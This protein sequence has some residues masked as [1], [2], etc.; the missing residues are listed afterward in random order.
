VTARREAFIPTRADWLHAAVVSGALFVLYALT[1]PR[2]VAGEDDGLF[3]LSSYYLGVEHAPG[4]PLFTLVGKLFTLL[5]FGSVAYRVH[6]ASAF[7]GALSGGACWLCA[8]ALL[9][10][11]VAA[12]LAAGA[13]A[14]SQVFWSQSVI[15]EVYTLNTFFFLVLAYLGLQGGRRALAW[16]AFLFGL[17]LSN[18]WPLMLLAG[19]ALAVLVW[20]RLAEQVKRVPLLVGFFLVGLTPYAWMVFL[21]WG[22]SPVNF[23]GPLQ[24]WTEIWYFVSRAGYAEIDVRPSA[25]W[26]DRLKFMAFV[27]QQ[28][29]V[30]FVFI[31]TALA[32][33]GCVVQWRV[34][35]KRIAAF[36]LLAFLGPT[37]GL[38][39]LLNFDYDAFQKHIFHVYP[40]PAYAVVALWTGLGFAWL[41]ERFVL[42]PVTAYGA[43]AVLGLTFLAAG[44]RT[45]LLAD[46]DWS[47]RYAQAVLRALPPDAVVFVQG[48]ADLGPMAYLHMV[49]NWRPDITLY[50]AKGLILGNRLFHPLRVDHKTAQAEVDNL[51]H[52]ETRPVVFTLD[53]YLGYARR[54]RWLYIEVDKSS[55]DGRRLA[56]DIPE[57][58]VR[59]FEDSLVSLNEPNNWARFFQGELRR[60]YATL[61]ARSLTPGVAAS[62]RTSRHMDLLAKDLYGAL[63]LA[64]GLMAHPA[65]YSA[66][67]VAALLERARD[68]MPSDAPKLHL[69]RF[70]HLRGLLR[71]D[72][73]DREGGLRDLETALAVWPVADNPAREPLADFQ[74]QAAKH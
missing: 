26:L 54:D 69:S 12:H 45:N 72:L 31:G 37:A 8:R 11:R 66:G 57:D 41:A 42:R 16:I 2:T 61:L 14:L 17:S 60:R 35:G 22:P 39:V 71:I 30:Q 27:G 67:A 34:L 15:A 68:T 65:G 50:Q 70:F 23:Y 7:F 36:L 51:I 33:V 53:T 43:A 48:D 5:P 74:R 3:I 40:L 32:A 6:L 52:R 13:L 18:H 44:A 62:P 59:F 58:A 64:E 10:P 46:Y 55:K 21:S 1:S 73:G 63:G 29:A 28:L 25:G 49:E 24:N 20:P 19:P 47:A 56:V 38:V 4:Y 9:Q